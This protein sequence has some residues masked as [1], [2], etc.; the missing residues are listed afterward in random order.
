MWTDILFSS[1]FVLLFVWLLLVIWM[2]RRLRSQ[3]AETFA[4]LGSPSLFLNNTP[5][6]NWLFLKF[7]FQE[8]WQRLGDRQ[9]S[10]GARVMQ[11]VFV[12]YMLGFVVTFFVV[13]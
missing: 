6:T 4:A 2:F 8:Q 12:T 3:H 13:F 10:I 9:L 5:R 7:L 1:L 11:V